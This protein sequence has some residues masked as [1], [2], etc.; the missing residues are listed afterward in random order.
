MVMDNELKMTMEGM[1]AAI[2]KLA[3]TLHDIERQDGQ[4]LTATN[5]AAIQFRANIIQQYS[6]IFNTVYE[7][8][9]NG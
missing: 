4:S 5:V 9:N 8:Q 3:K 7:E 1:R 6:G 2:N